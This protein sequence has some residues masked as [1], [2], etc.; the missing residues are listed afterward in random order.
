L[1]NTELI[2]ARR[3]EIAVAVN[4]SSQSRVTDKTTAAFRQQWEYSAQSA[5]RARGT[6]FHAL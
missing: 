1:C 4:G 5:R 6:I 2:L 3:S